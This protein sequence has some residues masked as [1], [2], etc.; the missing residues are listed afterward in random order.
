[1]SL[2]QFKGNFFL[3]EQEKEYRL[4]KLEQ[5]LIEGGIDNK[6]IPFLEKINK[7]PWIVTTQCCTGHSNKDLTPHID[8][9]TSNSFKF[10]WD[11]LYPYLS[12]YDFDLQ[13]TG[14]DLNMPRYCIWMTHKNWEDFMNIF[15]SLCEEIVNRGN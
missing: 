7:V 15:S 3:T 12:Q 14:T 6:M 1:M 11:M 5:E 13:V 10:I 9:R 4:K 8:F 2:N